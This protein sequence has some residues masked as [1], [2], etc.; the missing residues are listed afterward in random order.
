MKSTG[1]IWGFSLRRAIL[2]VL[3]SHF[4]EGFTLPG[5]CC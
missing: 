3:T 4:Q 1:F 2:S 5:S